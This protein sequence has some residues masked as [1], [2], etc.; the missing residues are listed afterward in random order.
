MKKIVIML[1]V[2]LFIFTPMRV[3]AECVDDSVSIEVQD[4]I[5]K[6]LGYEKYRGMSSDYFYLECAIVVVESG[7]TKYAI[8]STG[9][10]GYAQINYNVQRS[11][12]YDLGISDIFDEESNILVC[13]DV[14]Y[15]LDKMLGVKSDTDFYNVLMHYNGTK[16]ASALFRSG[17]Y[18]EYAKKVMEYYFMFKQGA[19][20]NCM[21][22]FVRNYEV[23]SKLHAGATKEMMRYVGGSIEYYE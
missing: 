7:C 15:D 1:M 4:A 9:D 21:E 14:L 16:N 22:D 19:E 23:S 3:S 8:S 20:V 17:C 2:L 11:R 18:S 13:T 6:V 5:K 12:I 10:Y